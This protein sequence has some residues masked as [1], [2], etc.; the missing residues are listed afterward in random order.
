[1]SID[2]R[3]Y[4]DVLAAGAPSGTQAETDLAAATVAGAIAGDEAGRVA[5]A[6]AGAEA[7]TQVA[8]EAGAAAGAAAGEIAGAQAGTG[9]GATS[10]AA[11]GATAGAAAGGTAGTAA[12]NAAMA[13]RSIT[14]GG[15]ASGGGNLSADRVITVTAADQTQAET[16]AST[17]VSMTPLGATQHFNARVST[18][19]RTVTAAADEAAARVLL[20]VVGLVQLAASGGAALV[21][22]LQSGTGA[23]AETLQ[24]ALRRV[25]PYPQQ[26]GAAGDGVA[27]DRAAVTAADV[28]AVARGVPLQLTGT[29][30]IG[31]DLTITSSIAG[32]G[33]LKPAAG[34]KVRLMGGIFGGQQQIFDL[35]AGSGAEIIL[36]DNVGDVFAAWWGANS[37]RTDND[38]PIQQAVNALEAYWADRTSPLAYAGG[39]VLLPRSICLTQRE[40]LLRNLVRLVGT[41]RGYSRLTAD[42]ASWVAGQVRMLRCVNY[43]TQ[44][45]ITGITKANPAVVTCAGG[46]AFVNGAVV[47]LE[48]VGGMTQVNDNGYT[49]ANATATTF[50]LSGTD[51]TA[52]GTYTSGGTA[53]EYRSQF[54]VRCEE[55][56]FNAGN[57]AAITEIALIESGNEQC[58]FNYCLFTN[59]R[60]KAI[61]LRKGYG[62]AASYVMNDVEIMGNN[63]AL[64]TGID[65]NLLFGFSTTFMDLVLNR[66]TVT[67]CVIGANI[68]DKVRVVLN[69]F[70]S[71]DAD[72]AVFLSGQARACGTGIKGQRD[73]DIL[74]GIDGNWT[75]RIDGLPYIQGPALNPLVDYRTGKSGYTPFKGEFL[76]GPMNYPFDGQPL[77]GG[78]VTGGT[79]P[80]AQTTRQIA[81]VTRPGPGQFRVTMTTGL[82]FA[83]ASNYYG[84][85]W[86]A[87]A[88]N[89]GVRCQVVPVTGTI[90]DILCVDA[91][92]PPVAVNLDLMAFAIYHKP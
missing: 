90:F 63:I 59:F 36:P 15:L 73:T 13:G 42:A 26:F 16:G 82:N 54:G 85:A 5:G 46:H 87:S 75:G 12:A 30:L 45:A 38:V 4:V 53:T 23:V 71:E 72:I 62:G 33:I 47:T 48:N 91:A 57:I 24:N 51:S 39:A 10:G 84:E 74:I 49:V 64:S 41:A 67:G 1:M 18:F 76:P 27:N 78:Y 20:G 14:G 9:A 66:V 83:S 81:S 65:A 3:R 79:T 80:P 55:V 77:F 28:A 22:F 11:A 43:E 70:C 32:P 69:T 31:T 34:V 92:V 89:V 50:E 19:M 56:E 29:Y 7:G 21:G 86:P 52:Y 8:Q 35:S 40:I 37:V 6:A 58:G 60:G 17:T 44:S 2:S 61:K 25:G 88:T 68:T